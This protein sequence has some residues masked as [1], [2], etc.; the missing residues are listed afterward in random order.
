MQLHILECLE[1]LSHA[2]T[3]CK[4]VKKKEDVLEFS[5]ECMKFESA[6]D[7][8]FASA[9]STIL[10]ENS[11]YKKQREIIQVFSSS[12]H[13][14]NNVGWLPLHWALA[15]GNMVTEEDIKT[16][17]AA[18]PMALSTRHLKGSEYVGRTPISFLL[19]QKK[20]SMSLLSFFLKIHPKAFTIPTSDDAK[21]YQV[22]PSYPLHIAAEHSESVEVLQKLLQVDTGITS[23]IATNFTHGSG[24]SYPLGLLCRRDEFPGFWDMISCLLEV[25]SSAKVI[26]NAI[27][28]VI[29]AKGHN[30]LKLIEMLLKANPEAANCSHEPLL[31]EICEHI[32]GDL[33]LQVLS[34][35]IA[36]NEDAII[37]A[38]EDENVG[39]L[40]VQYAAAYNTIEVLEFVW[41][42]FP[43]SPLCHHDNTLLHLAVNDTENE[44][45][46]VEAKIKFLTTENP[47]M[48][49][50]YN[51][52]G[53]TPLLN[54]CDNNEDPKMR[55]ISALI[56]ADDE[57]IMQGGCIASELNY[58][59]NLPLHLVVRS[60]PLLLSPLSETADIMRYFIDLYPEAISVKN[61]H[62]KYSYDYAV[63]KEMN[64]YF[65]RIL[66]KSDPTI[67]P[68][69][70]YNL[71]Y[72]E[73][74]LAMFI[75]FGAVSKNTKV[76][77][78]ASLRF[79]NKDLLKKVISFL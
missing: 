11:P 59:F 49:K 57:I 29:T 67:N 61:A 70:L 75:S 26:E 48:L 76:S 53:A 40:P 74:R 46:T 47:A 58:H 2:K 24:V 3:L 45:D 62:Q 51:D 20:P 79:E 65:I 21:F 35:F 30:T 17:Y 14:N 50:M 4:E 73:R 39:Y 1:A 52:W 16:T 10:D 23:T 36:I 56:A 60:S 43:V 34:L 42:E 5:V 54:Y 31:H 64:P 38:E 41:N 13:L 55:I 7:N 19:M 44:I 68:T 33:C 8:V 27:S 78:W 28:G 22:F 71:N 18:D 6:K 15:C 25:D 77:I 69:L 63:E 32:K 66:L 72:A 9:I 12:L 37:Y